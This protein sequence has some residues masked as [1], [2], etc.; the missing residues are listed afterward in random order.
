MPLFVRAGAIVPMGPVMQYTDQD[1]S[2][3]LTITVY[4]GADGSFSL[5]EDD[6]TST[7]YKQGA[8]S[9]IPIRYDERTG[10][11]TLGA[12]EGKGWT[13]MPASRTIRVRWVSEGKPVTDADAFDAQV[14]YNGRA[15]TIPRK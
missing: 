6:G 9:R 13:G 12:R 8:F 7:A 3:P 15:L 2:A 1:R 14:T 5:Y 11:V 10:A 4:T